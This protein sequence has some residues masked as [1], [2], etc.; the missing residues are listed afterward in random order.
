MGNEAV[1]SEVAGLI[2]GG[3]PTVYV[4]DVLASVVFYTEKLGL[5]VLYSAGEHFAMIDGGNGLQIGLH[6]N[7]GDACEAKPGRASS[8]HLGLEVVD[9]I[10]QV[11]KALMGRGVEFIVPGGGSTPVVDDDGAVKYA[12][13]GDLDGNPLYL[14]EVLK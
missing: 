11:V 3:C 14:Y 1:N 7:T 2:S 4:K 8:I 10:E 12:E 13:F 9:S 6:P 5:T